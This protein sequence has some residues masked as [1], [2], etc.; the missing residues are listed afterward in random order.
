MHDFKLKT[1]ILTI[2]TIFPVNELKSQFINAHFHSICV[3]DGVDSMKAPGWPCC[4]QQILP[5][6]TPTL[7]RPPV[8]AP[9]PVRRPIVAPIR[10]RAPRGAQLTGTA[11]RTLS[12]RTASLAGT[13]AAAHRNGFSIF[14]LHIRVKNGGTYAKVW[15]TS[16]SGDGC[17]CS[18]CFILCL[19]KHAIYHFPSE[20]QP[21]RC[22]GVWINTIC[23]QYKYKLSSLLDNLAY[24]VTCL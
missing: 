15:L 17:L 6:L 10:A 24:P 19:C 2:S 4:H 9:R 16:C 18:R 21:Q 13:A 12:Q 3:K 14:T 5:V 23:V 8:R 11:R 7:P 22:N 1:L 20:M